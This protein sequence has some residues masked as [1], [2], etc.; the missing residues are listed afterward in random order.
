MLEYKIW[1]VLTLLEATNQTVTGPGIK[2]L[3]MA[4]HDMAGRGAPNEYNNFGFNKQDW[5][6]YQSMGGHLYDQEIPVEAATSM[7]RILSHYKNTQIQNYD[8]INQLVHQDFSKL[9]QN[10]NQGHSDNKDKVVVY[11]RQALEYGKVKVYIPGGADRSL[12]IAIN[13]VVDSAFAAAGVEKTYDNYNK[14]SYPRYKKFS[15]D[16]SNLHSYR[17]SK[18]VLPKLV[19]LFKSRGL[20][21]VFESGTTLS[22][23]NTT[24]NSP[25]ESPSE[26][27]QELKHQDIEIIGE[28]SN[29][30]GKKLA[31]RFT[32]DFTRSKSIFDSLKSA[33]LSPKGISYA[34]GPSR[35]LLNIS[36]QEM[37]NRVKDHIKEAGLDVSPLEDF[38]SKKWTGTGDESGAGSPI[39]SGDQ[40][41]LLHFEDQPEDRIKVKVNYR[42]LTDGKK[43]FLKES[44]QYTFPA[45]RW[46]KNEYAYEIKGNYK[47]YVAFGRLLKRFGY[48][49]DELRRIVSA[50]SKDGRLEKTSW[51]GEHDNDD[52]F[53]KQIDERLPESN[54]DLYDEQKKGIA[55][56][57]GRDQAIVG[58]ETGL[59]KT[60]QLISAAA[61]KMQSKHSP[62]L[63][64]TL[65]SVQD[66]WVKEIMN[67]MGEQ[68]KVNISTDPLTPKKWTVVY[69]D[70]FS[71]GKQVDNYVNS[72]KRANFG[73]VIFDELHKLKHGKSKRSQNVDKTVENIPTRWGASATVSSN[74]PMDVR[75]QLK[76]IGHHLGDVDEKKFK[77]DFAGLGYNKDEDAEIKSAERLNRWLN[78]SGVYVRRSK[79]DIRD[80]PN[81]HVGDETTPVDSN[82]FNQ[83]Y[84]SKIKQYKDPELPISQLIAARETV[85]HLKTDKTTNNVI[86]TVSNG[87]TKSAAASKVVVFTNFIESGKQLV[88]KINA[89]LHELNPKFYVLPY[90]SGTKKSDRSQVKSRFT[91]D[92]NAK[93]L[94]MSM[95]MGGT[96]IDFPNAAQNMII[97]DF[98]WT[99][100]A[101]EQSEGRIYR[102]NTDHPVNI[103]Y[104]VGEGLDKDLFDLVQEKRKIATI[105]QKYRSEYHSSESNP[106]LLMKIL[107][108]QKRMH[109]IDQQMFNIAN[110]A[111]PGSGDAVKDQMKESFSKYIKKDSLKEELLYGFSLN[112]KQSL[113]ITHDPKG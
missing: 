81:L 83:Y 42:E 17:I 113:P 50:K 11:D 108:Y 88:D 87:L 58:D 30:F 82:K 75:N 39:S 12:V 8:Q 106:D 79:S 46:L 3:Q 49:V 53:L 61:L 76:I 90:L 5:T 24:Q 98:D 59:G 31:I 94:V 22:A 89:G 6:I 101:A 54:F 107:N 66:Q 40:N 19:E 27:P 29:Q 52:N 112:D 15:V 65:K 23:A 99:P 41:N 71:S 103:K 68:E 13:K 43:E 60:V 14:L 78:L 32:V 44:I 28:E 73:I 33:G 93:V 20:E 70:N 104:M 36:S 18:D 48:N 92:P 55:F 80:M 85:A 69:Y 34:S 51:E 102:I 105:I 86:Q 110:G 26:E 10:Q 91:D 97:N 2:A 37:F 56:L 84:S 109:A 16:K 72:L 63:I 38:G 96:G 25:Q 64:I 7:L 77:N 62:T 21:V 47:Q 95:R 1:R 57:Y 111:I 4:M 74:R 9:A 35:F 67:V 100:E 45:Y